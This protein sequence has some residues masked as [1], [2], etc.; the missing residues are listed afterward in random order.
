MT[1]EERLRVVYARYRE[2][3][4]SERWAAGNAGNLA[5]LR[6]RDTAIKRLLA[7]AGA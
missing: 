6:E 2:S 3:G 1:E 4:Y 7:E 5:A